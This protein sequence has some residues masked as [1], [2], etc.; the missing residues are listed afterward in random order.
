MSANH[1]NGKIYWIDLDLRRIE[2]A[3]FEGNNRVV[4]VHDTDAEGLAVFG[5]WLLWATKDGV[6]RVNTS[7]GSRRVKIW[8]GL[9]YVTAI[10]LVVTDRGDRDVGDLCPTDTCSHFCVKEDEEIILGDTAS[11]WRCSCPIGKQL[12]ENTCKEPVACNDS[13]FTCHSNGMCIPL[14]WRCDQHPDCE[15]KSDE[16]DC[17]NCSKG[18]CTKRIKS[19][20][21]SPKCEEDMQTCA[22]LQCVTLDRWCDGIPDCADSSDELDCPPMD[23]E[24]Q[25]MSNAYYAV[26]LGIASAGIVLIACI[27]LLAFICRQKSRNLATA[28]ADNIVMV[29]RPSPPPLSLPDSS[30]MLLGSGDL[31]PQ[32]NDGDCAA[33]LN[34]NRTIPGS[35]KSYFGELDDDMT[36]F[37]SSIV[38]RDCAESGASESVFYDRGHITGAS[39]TTGSAL[40]SRPAFDPPPSPITDRSLTCIS[41]SIPSYGQA[42]SSGR[43]RYNTSAGNYDHGSHRPRR[44]RKRHKARHLPTPC[45]STTEEGTLCDHYLFAPPPPTPLSGFSLSGDLKNLDISYPPSPSTGRSLYPPP[46]PS[47]LRCLSEEEYD[48]DDDDDDDQ[49][50]ENCNATCSNKTEK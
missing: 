9:P 48:D 40:T 20:S 34:N 13:Q 25:K 35:S 24:V 44:R 27:L 36:F 1:R 23:K 22:N 10:A 4:V 28:Y 19:S 50:H 21:A 31:C 6:E 2:S 17:R 43:Y 26:G 33:R 46:P 18:K 16:A 37:D 11:M 7:D 5:S 29:A 12:V 39:S 3:D 14:K 30:T 15:D 42:R 47:S 49:E 38:F 32:K 8:S 41:P 45:S